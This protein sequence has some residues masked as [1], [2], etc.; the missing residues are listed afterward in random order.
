MRNKKKNKK[1]NQSSNNSTNDNNR[2]KDDS[3]NRNN[4]NVIQSIPI[5]DPEAKIVTSTCFAC[6][7]EADPDLDS[8]INH[9]RYCS[10]SHRL[11]HKPEDRDEVRRITYDDVL[12]CHLNLYDKLT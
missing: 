10:K 1:N 7:S 2:K 5:N 4:G 11:L 3:K 12:C 9:V 6:L 8:E